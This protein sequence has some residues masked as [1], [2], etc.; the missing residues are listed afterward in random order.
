V[1]GIVTDVR[2]VH[3]LKTTSPIRVT[4]V[5]ITIDLSAEQAK[6][7]PLF[8]DTKV[9]GRTT[10]VINEQPTKH[11]T[12]R[13]NI[14][15]EDILIEVRD[16][17]DLKLTLP[18]DTRVEGRLT[19]LK[20]VQ[21]SKT[22]LL[23]AVTPSGMEIDVKPELEKV[24]SFSIVNELGKTADDRAV[25]PEKQVAPILVTEL[26]IIIDLNVLQPWND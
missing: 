17:Q 3:C 2:D 8:N 23:K 25:Q 6:N 19:D 1:E 7:T 5:G 14:P 15:V 24:Y 11:S 21:K 20:A 16:V 10:D 22:L 18:N 26:G 13:F 4:P 9:F 12:P